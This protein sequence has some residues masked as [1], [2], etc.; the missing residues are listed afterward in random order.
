MDYSP[1][2][3]HIGGTPEPKR[4]RVPNRKDVGIVVHAGKNFGFN[5]AIYCQGIYFP[6]TGECL[7]YDIKKVRPADD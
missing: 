4:V 7:Y 6:D 3:T 1:T 2:T 5:P